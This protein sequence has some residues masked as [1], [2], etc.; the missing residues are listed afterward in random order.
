MREQRRGPVGFA[1]ECGKFRGESPVSKDGEEFFKR[2]PNVSV[3]MS[4]RVDLLFS[5][6]EFGLKCCWRN[7]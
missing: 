7:V 3:S 1:P 5:G 4:N 2:L 6:C